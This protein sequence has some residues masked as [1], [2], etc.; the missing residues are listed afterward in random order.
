M[1][2]IWHSRGYIPHWEAGEI[3]QAITFRLND[4]LPKAV[5]ESWEAELRHLPDDM[6]N[7][8]RRKRIESALDQG[9]GAA[10][11]LD[12]RVAEIVENAFLH[13]DADRYRLHAWTIMP[14]HVH[15]I[16]TPLRNNGLSDIV[17]SWKSYTAK[18][19][20]HVLNRTGT[21]WSREYFDRAI[22]DEV[23]FATAVAYVDMNPVRAKLCT[24]P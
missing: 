23:H 5:L 4:N 14:N 2:N 8:R 16:S 10:H 9:H 6:A 19:A 13:F 3:P 7:T 12:T 1:S 20:D 15:V 18:A 21:F 17:H 11:L 22:R 24:S